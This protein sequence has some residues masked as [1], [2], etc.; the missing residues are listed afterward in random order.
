MTVATGFEQTSPQLVLFQQMRKF[1]IVVSSGS[2]PDNLRPTNRLT[3]RPRRACPCIPGSDSGC[4]TTALLCIPASQT[5]HTAAGPGPP[6]DRKGGYALSADPMGPGYQCAPGISPGGSCVAV[7]LMYS[8]PQMSAG[9]S[10]LP[11]PNI[12]V[13]VWHG[14]MPLPTRLVQSIPKVPRGRNDRR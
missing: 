5:T 2:G 12:S 7:K 4:R 9:P 6:W 13:S 8:K 11:A 14:T 3:D 1:R 10:C